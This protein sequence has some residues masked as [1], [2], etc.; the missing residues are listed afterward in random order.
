[1]IEVKVFIFMLIYHVRQEIIVSSHQMA[2]ASLGG[3][4]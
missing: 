2:M 4:L 3:I 1:L